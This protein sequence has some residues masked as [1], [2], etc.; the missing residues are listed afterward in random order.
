MAVERW[1][2][3]HQDNSGR[4]SVAILLSR[5]IQSAQD[6]AD[7]IPTDG[8]LVLGVAVTHFTMLFCYFQVAHRPL[9]VEGTFLHG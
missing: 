5:N 4:Q 9:R 1:L 7:L 8:R 2:L 3:N 6:N